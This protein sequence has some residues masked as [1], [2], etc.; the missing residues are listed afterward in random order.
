MTTERTYGKPGDLVTCQNGHPIC[1]VAE[2]LSKAVVVR[3]SHFKNW[4]HE[5]SA[6]GQIPPCP[7]CG[8]PFITEFSGGARVFIAG[9]W[10]PGNDDVGAL[11]EARR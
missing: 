2:D 1:E 10:R 3:H 7:I 8:Q 11:E 5:I 6:T 9:R 4:R